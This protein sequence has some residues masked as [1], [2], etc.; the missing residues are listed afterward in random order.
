MKYTNPVRG[1]N[2]SVYGVLVLVLFFCGKLY[3]G[4]RMYGQRRRE[5][6]KA[7]SFW[8][9]PAL[10]QCSVTTAT[11]FTPGYLGW[12]ELLLTLRLIY[13]QANNDALLLISDVL[14]CRIMYCNMYC[15]LWR[16][17]WWSGVEMVGLGS[18]SLVLFLK[19]CFGGPLP[20]PASN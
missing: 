12:L 15:K 10:E 4:K 19:A 8:L 20:P 7:L 16:C 2:Y 13:V 18:C 9:V 3:S 14:S 1:I 11:H 5:A 6:Q 17:R